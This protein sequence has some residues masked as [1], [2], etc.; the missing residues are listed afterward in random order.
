MGDFS[1]CD[2]EGVLHAIVYFMKKHTPAKCNYN[3]YDIE[4]KVINKAP[5]E[6]R[7]G[8]EGAGYPLKLITDL[9]NVEY[10]MTKKLLNRR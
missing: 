10:F 6:W 1:Q 3:M 2:K 9:K 8:C 7:P 5:Q 4:L